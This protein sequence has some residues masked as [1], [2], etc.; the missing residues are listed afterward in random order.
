MWEY[1]K[2]THHIWQLFRQFPLHMMRFLST[3]HCRLVW[4]HHFGLKSGRPIYTVKLRKKESEHCLPFTLL[5]ALLTMKGNAFICWCYRAA[6][7]YKQ[8]LPPIHPFKYTIEYNTEPLM[9]AW[10][11]TAFPWVDR[12]GGKSNEYNELICVWRKKKR[13]TSLFTL[14]DSA[15]LAFIQS[16]GE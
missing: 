16:R 1:L 4:H 8:S 12:E 15:S 14:S 7:W 5:L 10:L 11:R 3:F 13:S 6:T 2:I 9:T